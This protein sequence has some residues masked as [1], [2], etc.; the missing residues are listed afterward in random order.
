MIS[1]LR[2]FSDMTVLE[3]SLESAHMSRES[4][5]PGKHQTVVNLAGTPWPH[6][7][8]LTWAVDL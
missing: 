1:E 2:L 8:S 5:A 4:T 6:C 3:A 7:L